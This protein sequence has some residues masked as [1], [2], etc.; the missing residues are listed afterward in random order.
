MSRYTKPD[1]GNRGTTI[2]S[3]R[4]LQRALNRQSREEKI[5]SA[6]EQALASIKVN[7]G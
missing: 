3:V 5:K 1:W 7:N 4:N 2:Q 6:L